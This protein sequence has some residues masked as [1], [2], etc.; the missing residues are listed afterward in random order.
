M[1]LLNFL[2]ISDVCL[3]F[4]NCKDGNQVVIGVDSRVRNIESRMAELRRNLGM[5]Q[6][7]DSSDEINKEITELNKELLSLRSKQIASSILGDYID[8]LTSGSQ[9]VDTHTTIDSGSMIFKRKVSGLVDRLNVS[10]W[11]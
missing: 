11:C 2:E 5:E 8:V 6:Y 1:F 7:S 4:I 10:I 9:F 3:A